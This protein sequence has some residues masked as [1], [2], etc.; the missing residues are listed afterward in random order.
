MIPMIRIIA[1]GPL[2]T[3]QDEGR[4]GYGQFGFSQSGAADAKSMHIANLLVGNNPGEGVFEM[5]LKGITAQFFCDCTIALTGADI[6]ALLNGNPIP[7]YAA[8]SV[9]AGSILHM[10]TAKSGCRGYLAVGGG[11]DL[12]KEMGSLSTG[13]KFGIGG[14][15]GRK[16]RQKDEIFLRSPSLLQ[17]LSSRVCPPPEFPKKLEIRA[18]LGP[19]DDYFTEKDKQTFFSAPYKVTP[20]SDRMGIRLEGE[21]LEGIDGMDIVSDGI[22]PGSVQIPGNGQPI[23]LMCDRQTTGGYAKI[24][25]VY[26]GD[27]SKLAQAVPG[28]V[29]YFLETSLEEAQRAL[30]EDRQKQNRLAEK[31]KTPAA[32]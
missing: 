17:N 26:S 16:L 31:F 27:L 8:L 4:I 28:T 14:F 7:R 22:A 9:T 2:C 30:K 29:V 25:T 11:F 15:H 32:L 18:I 5:T 19:Q 23:V 24:A 6:P 20:A 10:A 21:A 13:L 12:K 1:A 3:V